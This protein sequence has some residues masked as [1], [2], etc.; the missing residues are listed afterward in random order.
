[1]PDLTGNSVECRLLWVSE[2]E[3]PD[4]LAGCRLVAISVAGSSAVPRMLKAIW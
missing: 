4:P 2:A 3:P 1:M